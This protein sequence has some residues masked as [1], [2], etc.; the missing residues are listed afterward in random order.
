[1]KTSKRYNTYAIRQQ[2]YNSF[3]KKK[4]YFDCHLEVY[5]VFSRKT[6]NLA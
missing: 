6:F 4:T 3:I 1:M 2:Q 5:D